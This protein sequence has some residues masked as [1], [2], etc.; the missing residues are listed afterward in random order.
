MA[1]SPSSID[2]SLR[3]RSLSYVPFWSPSCC[4]IELNRRNGTSSRLF[5]AAVHTCACNPSRQN[6]TPPIAVLFLVQCRLHT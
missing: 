4:S 3:L 1:A 2:R 6:E 5:P